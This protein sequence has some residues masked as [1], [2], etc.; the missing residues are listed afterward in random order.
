MELFRRS[1]LYHGHANSLRNAVESHMEKEKLHGLDSHSMV[2]RQGAA[3]SASSHGGST[4]RVNQDASLLSNEA[5]TAFG[6][7][8]G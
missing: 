5:P 4:P 7:H 3:D 8:E 6:S 1:R 2:Y